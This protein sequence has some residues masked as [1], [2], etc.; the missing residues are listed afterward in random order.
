MGGEAFGV[1][2]DLLLDLLQRQTLGLRHGEID[3]QQTGDPQTGKEGVRARFTQATLHQWKA[4]S[5]QKIGAEVG[6]RGD[7]NGRSAN[8]V[9]KHLAN[10]Q[11]SDGSE[12]DLVASHVH[13]QRDD[14]DDAHPSGIAH[15]TTGVPLGAGQHKQ[16]H[17]HPA[18]PS[19]EQRTTSHLVHRE[20]RHHGHEQ[21]KRTDDHRGS[22]GLRCGAESGLLQDLCRVVQDAGLS[23]DLLPYH[24]LPTHE[25]YLAISSPEEVQDG[26]QGELTRG[27]GRFFHEQELAL[28]LGLR[29]LASELQQSL[30]GFLPSSPSRQQPPRRRRQAVHENPQ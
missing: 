26:I 2:S 4:Q 8:A 21:L 16:G 22:G 14:T 13:Q 15:W 28:D 24:E 6:Q 3:G 7:R 17:H 20:D 5:H 19:Q 10:Q 9:G 11:P 1:Q 27:H 25:Q 29:N 12:T 23:G 30:F 18:D